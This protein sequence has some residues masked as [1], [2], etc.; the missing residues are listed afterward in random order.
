MYLYL[1]KYYCHEVFNIV[2]V[3]IKL[4]SVCKYVNNICSQLHTFEKKIF[5]NIKLYF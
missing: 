1:F 4:F 3:L 2:F 5:I